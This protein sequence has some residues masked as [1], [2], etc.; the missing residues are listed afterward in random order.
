MRYLKQSSKRHRTLTYQR[1]WPKE[2][3]DAAKA[4]G[5]GALF[6]MPT[7]VSV[8]ANE[9]EQAAA[10]QVGDAEF[11]KA[12]A[13][14]RAVEKQAG[15]GLVTNVSINRGAKRRSGK[16]YNKEAA[17]R[18]TKVPT[19]YQLL[20]HWFQ[21]HP[22]A[23]GKAKETRQRHWD[24]WISYISQDYA[25]IQSTIDV[26]HSAFDAMQDAMLARGC[27]PST[28]ARCRNS[29]SGVLTWASAEYRIGWHLELKGLPKHSPATKMPLTPQQQAKLLA[30]CE[31]DGDG[32]AAMLA[33][34]LQGGLMPSEIQRLDKDAVA[35]S[36]ATE[37]P[38]VVIGAAADT[39]T[40]TAA[41]RRVVPIVIAL[42]LIQQLLGQA[43]SDLQGAAD[44]SARVNK[45]LRSREEDV[46]VKTTGH[47]LR[48]TFRANA[49]A[50][51]ANPMHVAAIAGWSGSGINPVMLRYGSEG[52][53]QS[54]LLHALAAA[55]RE[56]HWH[57]L[58]EVAGEGETVV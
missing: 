36:L 52:L 27:A 2:L 40:K 31:A 51:G 23:E 9:V 41:R 6:T 38:H 17:S 37:V 49:V 44:P 19:L 58:R 22:E 1:A 21:L 7:G 35:E 46:G 4:A 50:C 42:P 54:A 34:M 53:S 48:H 18:A 20:S 13:L 39:Q 55:S 57:L 43:I 3:R 16:L 12:V 30:T 26:I 32:T 28:V 24:E 29:V 45:R 5:K 8:N 10:K 33:L 15:Y 14:L 11:S 56:I 47:A 25:C